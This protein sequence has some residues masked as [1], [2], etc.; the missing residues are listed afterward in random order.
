MSCIVGIGVAPPRCASTSGP[1]ADGGLGGSFKDLVGARYQFLRGF[2][3]ACGHF[4]GRPL[5]R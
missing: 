1:V 3:K 4:L 5:A 2:N